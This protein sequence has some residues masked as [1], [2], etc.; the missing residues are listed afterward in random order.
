VRQKRSRDLSIGPAARSLLA[1]LTVVNGFTPGVAYDRDEYD[2]WVDDDGDCVN[3]RHEV[4]IRDSSATVV[5]SGCSLVSGRWVDPYDGAVYSLASAVQVDHFVPLAHAHRVRAWAWDEATKRPPKTG[6][7]EFSAPSGQAD[8]GRTN[9]D[10][11]DMT[12]RPLVN[13]VAHASNSMACTFACS[14]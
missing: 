14:S 3:T 5:R 13:A 10:E 9:G 2:S 12:R 1:F 11:G 7:D 4:L 6:P 8:A